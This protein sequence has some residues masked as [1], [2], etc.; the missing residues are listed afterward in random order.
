MNILS[1]FDGMSCGQIAINRI[2]IKNYTYYASEIKK[3]AIKCTLDNYPDTIQLGDVTKWQDW[4]LPK[5]DLLMFGSPCQDFSRA[6]KVRSGLEGVKSSLFYT[7]VDILNHY[8]PK[9]FLMENVIMPA[10]QARIISD[11]LGVYPVRIN[12]ALV[13]GMMRDRLYWTNVKGDLE[14]DFLGNTISQ[15]ADKK[16][17]LQDV[18]ES[19]YADKE[20][21][22]TMLVS[23]ARQLCNRKRMMHRYFSSGFTQL[24]F[25]D[26]NDKENTCR[27]LKRRERERLQTV[28][29]GY[30]DGVTENQ[31][32]D[33]LGDGWTV[34]VICHLLKSLAKEFK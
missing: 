11:I 28:P 26:M 10:E 24:I 1:L 9:Y 22:R 25:E 14:P 30:T 3:H 16:I 13:S 8:K 31:A 5:I 34:D 18:L 2:G 6:N 4:N 23:D 32:A 33:L 19:G 12:S 17:L 21:A 15:P 27:Y 20:K 29:E 7:A